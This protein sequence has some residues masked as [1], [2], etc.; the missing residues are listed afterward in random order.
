MQSA[1]MA[2]DNKVLRVFRLLNEEFDVIVGK[3]ADHKKGESPLIVNMTVHGVR[4]AFNS[5]NDDF[6]KFISFLAKEELGETL[7]PSNLRDLK[8]KLETIASVYQAVDCKG[9]GCGCG[10]AEAETIDEE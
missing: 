4:Y 3:S 6:Q 1:T 9:K 7:S 2:K 5:N 10:S 8:L